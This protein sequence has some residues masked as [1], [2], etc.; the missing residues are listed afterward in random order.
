MGERRTTGSDE[1]NVLLCGE[2]KKRTTST[3]YM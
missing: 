3:M 1:P 2:D